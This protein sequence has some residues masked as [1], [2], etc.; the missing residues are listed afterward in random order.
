MNVFE[1]I[2][3]NN[4]LRHLILV[5]YYNTGGKC[6][7][8]FFTPSSKLYRRCAVPAGIMRKNFKG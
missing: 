5:N 7:R 8:N 6:E 3:H 4:K 2:K 1:P